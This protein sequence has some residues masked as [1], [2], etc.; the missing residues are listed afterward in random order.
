[1]TTREW[2]LRPYRPGDEERILE[3][4]NGIFRPF[5]P[6]YVDRSLAHWRW[7]YAE[8]GHEHQTWVAE[9]PDGRF[10]GQYTAIP[11]MMNI[12]GE[13]SLTGQA[14]DTC[15][16][17]A[18]R[19]SLRREGLFLTMAR[20]WFDY[21]GCDERDRIVYGFP[22]EQ[23]FPVGTRLL[24]YRPVHCP[25]L[26]LNRAADPE[27]LPASPAV[28]VERVERFDERA[29]GL[30]E[31]L[32]DGLGLSTWRDKA[33]L[34]WRFVRSPSVKYEI[35]QA[36]RGG[37]LCAWVV[38][39]LG[40]FKEKVAPL[41]DV[42]FDPADREALGALV[43]ELACDARAAGLQT[44]R[45]WMPVS[46]PH[47]ET[48]KSLGFLP[49]PSRFNLCIR[50]FNPMFDLSYAKERWYYTMGDSDIY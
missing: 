46:F 13:R 33:Y 11:M 14:V 37:E 24:H 7:L 10:I 1:M 42:L 47:H 49:A 8:N 19:R 48:L 43:R 31:K 3:L 32:R 25:V 28:T 41:V 16:D 36:T 9:L 38:Y 34:D 2:T 18:Y 40:W 5:N 4:F 15:V 44:I 29:D 17:P 39:R 12:R 20:S 26:E 30:Y 22:N 27:G 50:I 6:D 21:W 35:L 45:T 23:A